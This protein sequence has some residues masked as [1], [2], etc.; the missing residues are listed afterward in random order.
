MDKRANTDIAAE[1]GVT[2]AAIRHRLKKIH[3]K[4]ENISP[5]YGVMNTSFIRKSKRYYR[6]IKAIPHYRENSLNQIPAP[7]KTKTIFD[8]NFSIN[9]W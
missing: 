4:L 2:L 9:R 3:E 5:D 1:E 6:I 8:R 7:R